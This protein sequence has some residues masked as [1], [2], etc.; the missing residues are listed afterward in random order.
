[1]QV[2]NF[3]VREVTSSKDGDDAWGMS[4]ALVELNGYPLF[5]VPVSTVGIMRH[6]DDE[7]V[8]AVAIWIRH[9]LGDEA[10]AG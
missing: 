4:E 3:T 9:K 10:V 5:R 2:L 6:G 1:M 8:E 7:L